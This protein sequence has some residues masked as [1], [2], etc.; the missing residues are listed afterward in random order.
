MV[1]TFFSKYNITK[2]HL[3]NILLFYG[4]KDKHDDIFIGLAQNF[5]CG[6]F[7]KIKYSGS[8]TILLL[9]KSELSC[10]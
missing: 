8:S 6:Y 4:C 1:L 10:L 5:V 9:F 7:L 3:C 2:I